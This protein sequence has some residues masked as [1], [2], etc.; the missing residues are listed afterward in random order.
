MLKKKRN[1]VSI[2]IISLALLC[3][4][5][6]KETV[7]KSEKFQATYIN[8]TG[9]RISAIIYTIEPFPKDSELRCPVDLPD[10]TV[11]VLDI[12]E[13]LKQ[14]QSVAISVEFEHD[15]VSINTDPSQFQKY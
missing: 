5:C 4:G 8:R 14:F 7:I 12:P 9:K 2:F 11:A 3:C 6:S 10:R 13:D 15:E 1:A